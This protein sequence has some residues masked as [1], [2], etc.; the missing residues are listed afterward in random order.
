MATGKKAVAKAIEGEGRHP[1][2]RRQRSR[3]SRGRIIR[4][5]MD[6][7][8]E[9]DPSP[10]AAQ[11]AERAGVGLRSVFRHFDDKES[12]FRE[13]NNI[14]SEAYLPQLQEPYRSP[15]WRDQLFELVERRAKFYEALAPFRIATSLQRFR[16][17][18]LLENYR[19]LLRWERDQLNGV[20]PDNV[21][22]DSQRARAILLTTSFDTW[23]LFRQDEELSNKQTVEVIKQ[24]LQDILDQIKG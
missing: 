4:A 15:Q 6:L 3:D 21:R 23:R 17:P 14:L 16:S 18:A 1:D 12:I 19:R 13:M 10:S 5:M 20:L 22:R 24:L 8:V 2:G 11:V 9:G 7:I